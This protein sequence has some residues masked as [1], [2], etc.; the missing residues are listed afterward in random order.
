MLQEVK[1]RY[2]VFQWTFVAATALIGVAGL[3]AVAA[4]LTGLPHVTRSRSRHTFPLTSP[5]RAGDVSG[6]G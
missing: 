4:R 3:V 5:H 1:E 6:K 2:R